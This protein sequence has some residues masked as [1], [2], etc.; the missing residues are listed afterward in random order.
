[1]KTTSKPLNRHASPSG[2]A[3]LLGLMLVTLATTLLGGGYALIHSSYRN[4]ARTQAYNS[5]VALAEGVTEEAFTKWRQKERALIDDIAKGAQ[6]AGSELT[7]NDLSGIT[8]ST[9]SQFTAAKATLDNFQIKPVQPAVALKDG[10]WKY[11]E[12]SGNAQPGFSVGRN[13]GVRSVF[14]LAK[15]DVTVPA[16]GSDVKVKMRRIFEK[17]RENPAL[18]AIFFDDDCEMHPGPD[19]IVDGWV[20]TNASLFTA[21]AS[22]TYKERVD[23]AEDWEIGY[24]PLDTSHSGTPVAPNWTSTPSAGMTSQPFGYDPKN[25]FDKYDTDPSNDDSNPNNDSYIELIQKPD[26]NYSDPF[27][28]ERLYTNADLKI[29]VT[30]SGVS[31]RTKSGDAVPVADTIKT[32]INK[33]ETAYLVY[34]DPNNSSK[35]HIEVGPDRIYPNLPWQQ[36]TADKTYKD[37]DVQYAN[38][39]NKAIQKSLTTETIHDK[40]IGSDVKVTTV[41]VNTLNTLINDSS[42]MPSWG[43]VLWISDMTADYKTGKHRAIRLADAGTLPNRRYSTTDELNNKLVGL[44]VVSQ[45]PVYVQGDFNTGST[46]SAK[47]KS[48][49]T[50][51]FDD[52]RDKYV[53]TGY[54]VRPAAVIAD[55]VNLLSNAWLDANSASKSEASNT[56]INCAIV[57]GNVPT[58]E[59]DNTGAVFDSNGVRT[60]GGQTVAYS[61]GVENFPRFLENWGNKYIT[62][63]GSMIQLYRSEQAFYKWG[64]GNV[65]DAPKRRWFYEQSYLNNP[66]PGFPFTYKMVRQRWFMEG[67]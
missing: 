45:N 27:A 33:G 8:S 35:F 63:H 11:T 17:Q 15:A 9:S 14:Y 52:F 4:A 53:V 67:A 28:N 59:T 31:I 43:G 2:N 57:S 51:A 22:L 3:I 65:Y 30:A 60:S 1:M 38:P 64:K 54:E 21:H 6:S 42:L 7:A 23:F 46:A 19:Q 41:H 18:Y 5:G 58:G 61:G 10:Q 25:V 49:S 29:E 12:T 44:T 50:T 24:H 39:L 32:T 48:N 13:G 20:H 55:A 56:T 34:D 62:Y 37:L 66:P 26:P 36:V 40:R 47:P 16:L